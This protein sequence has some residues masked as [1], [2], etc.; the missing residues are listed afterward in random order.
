MTISILLPTLAL[1]QGILTEKGII[2]TI[3]LLALTSLDEVLLILQKL[4]TLLQN[5]LS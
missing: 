2:N 4:F 3:D 5:M 1:N